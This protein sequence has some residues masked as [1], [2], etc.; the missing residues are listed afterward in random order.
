MLGV[1]HKGIAFPL[2]WMT[3]IKRDNFNTEG[4]VEPIEE[5]EVAAVSAK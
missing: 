1:G 2:V 3:L 5:S 4:R